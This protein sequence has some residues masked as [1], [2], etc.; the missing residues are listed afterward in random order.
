M[1]SNVVE[2][3]VACIGAAKKTKQIDTGEPRPPG[4]DR[5]R[6]GN[7]QYSTYFTDG[8]E[9]FADGRPS[10][11]REKWWERWRM[12]LL[13]NVLRRASSTTVSRQGMTRSTVAPLHVGSCRDVTLAL[14]LQPARA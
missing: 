12:D 3:G 7:V 5:D 9:L 8:D 1:W 4:P 10:S 2:K 11:L 13:P 6:Y 14:A